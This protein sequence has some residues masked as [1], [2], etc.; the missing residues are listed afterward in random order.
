MPLRT[1]FPRL[2]AAAFAVSSV[3]AAQ[4]SEAGIEFF[5]EKIEA[6]LQRE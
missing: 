1:F 3:R 5:R 2:A 4:E 6:V